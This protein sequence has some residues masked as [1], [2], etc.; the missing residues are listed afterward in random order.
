MLE[1]C[2]VYS[3]SFV[4][5]LFLYIFAGIHKRICVKLLY[6]KERP[7]PFE[8]VLSLPLI[9]ILL[10][11]LPSLES[12]TILQIMLYLKHSRDYN[13][14]LLLL[15]VHLILILRVCI[16]LY[17]K[18]GSGLHMHPV[19]HSI[20]TTNCWSN[21]NYKY[22]IKYKKKGEDTK[23]SKKYAMNHLCTKTN[24]QTFSRKTIYILYTRYRI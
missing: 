14:F 15:V 21:T 7:V 10:L 20:W 3:L 23:M 12:N 22:D 8:H 6:E 11:F 24:T 1:L 19:A 18:D 5:L 16:A 2:S 4:S 17:P 9:F 13:F